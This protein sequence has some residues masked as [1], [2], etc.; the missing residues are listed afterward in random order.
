MGFVLFLLIASEV[1]PFVTRSPGSGILHT[2]ARLAVEHC[3]R[4]IEREARNPTDPIDP[5]VTRDVTSDLPDVLEPPP[6]PPPATPQQQRRG[7][8]PPSAAPAAPMKRGLA[9]APVEAADP[10]HLLAV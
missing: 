7:S 2:A 5:E 1:L 10:W 9:F 3:R 6:P 8:Q 4:E